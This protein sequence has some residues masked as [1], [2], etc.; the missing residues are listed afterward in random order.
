[1]GDDLGNNTRK[2][3]CK[4]FEVHFSKTRSEKLLPLFSK[5]P[6]IVNE[7]NSTFPLFPYYM[8]NKGIRAD[9]LGAAF[10]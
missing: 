2:V 3:G 9:C 7:N 10:Y 8:L 6:L 5:A 4:I 1:M